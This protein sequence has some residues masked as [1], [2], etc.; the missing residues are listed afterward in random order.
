MEDSEYLEATPLIEKN[1]YYGC[2][3]FYIGKA[4]AGSY[5]VELATYN[6][7]DM[8]ELRVSFYEIEDYEEYSG[9]KV[10]DWTDLIE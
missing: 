8:G 2:L 9:V 5:V 1:S 7:D 3:M 6:H 4:T 10:H